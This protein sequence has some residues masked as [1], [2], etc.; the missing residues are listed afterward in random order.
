VIAL[1]DQTGQRLYFQ[2]EVKRVVSLVPSLTE[3]LVDM[4]IE[5]RILGITKFCVHPEGIKKKVK[6]IGGT[7]HPK[8]A[9][10]IAIEPD[11]I[12]A[13]KEE[14]RLEDIQ[15][16]RQHAQVYV[17][18]IRN[19]SDTINF[20]NDINTI[21]VTREAAI[22]AN[23]IRNIQKP[24]FDQIISV[25]YL[26]WKAPYMTVGHDTFIHYMLGRYG[27]K[28]IF[29]HRTRYPE[30]SIE[31]IRAKQPQVIMLSSEPYPFKEAHKR[32]IQALVPNSQVVLVDGEMFSWYGSRILLADSYIKHLHSALLS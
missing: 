20:I 31:E 25:C 28:N 32:E 16:L 1:T 26:I 10:I 9:E 17:S 22:L 27:L 13:N 3:T 7:K 12:I 14:N 23:Q 21:F 5:D 24:G 29:G 6:S 15:I 11:L 4:G 8:I 18:D 30:T 19:F 2:T